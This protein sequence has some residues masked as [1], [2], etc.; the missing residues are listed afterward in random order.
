MSQPSLAVHLCTE[1]G[2]GCRA[3]AR[4]GRA[5]DHRGAAGGEAGPS[6]RR[7]G[8]WGCQLQQLVGE[9]PKAGDGGQAEVEVLGRGAAA[10]LR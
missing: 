4:H 7:C 10:N 8:A 2:H 6:G 1:K 3:A 9:G 5:R